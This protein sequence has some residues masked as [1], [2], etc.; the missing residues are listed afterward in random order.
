MQ[1]K[2]NLC[3]KYRTCNFL[4]LNLNAKILLYIRN[5]SSEQQSNDYCSV[6]H[7]TN[8]EML[9]CYMN[10][11]KLISK[12][13]YEIY[14]IHTPPYSNTHIKMQL[15][16]PMN[17]SQIPKAG[18]LVLVEDCVPKSQ[19]LGE[20]SRTFYIS[21]TCPN[22]KAQQSMGLPHL[23]VLLK[24]YVNCEERGRHGSNSWRL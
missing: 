18:L 17:A 1:K 21:N 14:T 6:H 10:L 4:K 8:Q 11:R 2:P 12:H 9:I 7:G 5:Y 24:V 16:T 15:W 20:G 19:L 22:A 13:H 23:V 3:G